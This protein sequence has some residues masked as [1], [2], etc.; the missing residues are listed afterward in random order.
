MKLWTEEEAVTAFMAGWKRAAISTKDDVRPVFVRRG[1]F[2]VQATDSF[3]EQSALLW[4]P[5]RFFDS[6]AVVDV[7][8]GGSP[9]AIRRLNYREPGRIKTAALL[10]A[11]SGEAARR[12]FVL[13]LS[14]LSDMVLAAKGESDSGYRVALRFARAVNVD[15]VPS[16]W[17]TKRTSLLPE[18]KP[19]YPAY[20]DEPEAIG[21][22]VYRSCLSVQSKVVPARVRFV[23]SASSI[24]A[25]WTDIEKVLVG[26][27]EGAPS[28]V[29][30]AW[31]LVSKAAL[32]DAT[33]NGSRQNAAARFGV[34]SETF[35][36]KCRAYGLEGPGL[37]WRR[38]QLS[39]GSSENPV[40]P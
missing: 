26:V 9:D 5:L 8:V 32:E 15:K 19:I 27:S 13:A 1:I 34:A 16:P 35:G 29:P 23:R 36:K 38:S 7:P 30:L 40:S 28:K 12:V 31:Q 18:I 20:V 14:A 37:G 2:E 24:V 22:W 39:K 21:E 6:D 11:Y 33:R 17:C 10:E 25:Q 4:L 3:R